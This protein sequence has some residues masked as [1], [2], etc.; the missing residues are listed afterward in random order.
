MTRYLIALLLVGT[1]VSKAYAMRI[2]SKRL[3]L[4]KIN[5]KMSDLRAEHERSAVSSGTH[6]AIGKTA[7]FLHPR[8]CILVYIDAPSGTTGDAWQ[9][10]EVPDG[11]QG[12]L[13][14]A[15]EVTDVMVREPIAELRIPDAH[16]DFISSSSFDLD[17][18]EATKDLDPLQK[19]AM[20]MVRVN[21]LKE[22]LKQCIEE[23]E[24]QLTDVE[25][26]VGEGQVCEMSGAVTPK[27]LVE[28]QR[29]SCGDQLLSD[30]QAYMHTEGWPVEKFCIVVLDANY[31]PKFH[32]EWKG[33]FADLNRCVKN[34]GAKNI[35]PYV[36]WD[37][38]RGCNSVREK[39]PKVTKV[40]SLFSSGKMSIRHPYCADP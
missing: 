24:D 39:A 6:A 25:L 17:F 19:S 27:P 5:G 26:G 7:T 2:N 34:I 3:E 14:E 23:M 33:D 36:R 29:G 22:H 1:L 10:E 21:T 32:Y 11:D 16:Y 9:V 15:E 30:P 8:L 40:A 20:E 28:G 35:E 13:L 4:S 37:H 12:E 18:W 38:N 31:R